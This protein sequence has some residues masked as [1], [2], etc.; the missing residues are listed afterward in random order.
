MKDLLISIG[1]WHALS[2]SVSRI[3]WL[4]Y[5]LY[6]GQSYWY[7]LKL[8]KQVRGDITLPKEGKGG[9]LRTS[10]GNYWVNKKKMVY[11]LNPRE[12]RW[13]DF[14][15]VKMYLEAALVRYT[16][17]GPK[18]GLHVCPWGKDFS[19]QHSAT[20]SHTVS[21]IVHYSKRMLSLIMKCTPW[22]GD[23]RPGLLKEL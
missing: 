3:T 10:W 20:F 22:E 17:V 9:L 13:L 19:S 8:S 18:P 5:Q 11:N 15:K 23:Y 12:Y 2:R 7:A 4:T 14:V 6:W 16:T 1:K 21:W